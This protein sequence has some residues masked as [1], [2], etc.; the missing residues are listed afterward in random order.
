MN[1]HIFWKLEWS[2]GELCLRLVLCWQWLTILWFWGNM[3][4]GLYRD[5]NAK[6]PLY[7]CLY[8]QGWRFNESYMEQLFSKVKKIHCQ[9]LLTQMPAGNDIGLSWI[10][11]LLSL[12]N[13]LQSGP[14]SANWQIK[15]TH[16]LMLRSLVSFQPCSLMKDSSTLSAMRQMVQKSW[17]CQST[18]GIKEW[19]S[20]YV[21]LAT[22]LD[23]N[24]WAD[25]QSYCCSKSAYTNSVLS[26]CR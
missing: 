13:A 6:A 11:L 5:A 23:S 10:L 21:S 8:N 9:S 12:Q 17:Q 20:F 24:L 1:I 4:F 19:N 7:D 18:L 16:L 25:K 14:S 22:G 3:C 15:L 26:F 2:S